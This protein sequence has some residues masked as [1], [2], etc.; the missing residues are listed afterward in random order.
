MIQVKHLCLCF[1]LFYSNICIAKM[2]K[3]HLSTFNHLNA[4]LYHLYRVTECHYSCVS[5][6]GV[7]HS[8]CCC[9]LYCIGA[10]KCL[11]VATLKSLC[12]HL[13]SYMHRLLSHCSVIQIFQYGHIYCHGAPLQ[14]RNY[15]VDQWK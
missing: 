2:L 9:L 6:C 14:H 10:Q 13:S 12:H 8:P 4:L 7:L 11:A 5:K 3:S 15:W 1:V